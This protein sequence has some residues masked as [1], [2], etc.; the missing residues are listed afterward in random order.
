MQKSSS[1]F[2]SL[3]ATLMLLVVSAACA[4][5]V[6]EVEVTRYQVLEVPIVETQVVE[7]TREVEVVSEIQVEVTREIPVTVMPTPISSPGSAENPFQLIFL[8]TAAEE[9]IQIRGGFLL[10]HLAQST[11]YTFEAIIPSDENQA[12]EI[13]CNNPTTTIAMLT[14][15]QYVDANSRCGAFA[16]LTAT[17]F[18]VPYELGM[19]VSR[20][21]S[22]INV[23]EDISF[24]KIGVP[25]LSDVS[26]YQLFAKDIA[27]AGLPGVQFTEYGTSTSALIALLNKEIDIAA[28]IYNPP[29]M[30]VRED[31][32]Q[33]GED[34][35][36]IWRQL[37]IAP[38][39]NP[40]GFV[41][42]N[43]GPETGGYRIR[44]ARASIF[45]TYPTIFDETK[46]LLLSR[47]YPNEMIAL[48]SEFPIVAFNPVVNSIIG[49]TNSEACDQAMC[50]SDFYQWDGVQTIN[51]GFYNVVRELNR[52]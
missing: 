1:I 35:P 30:P 38:R 6:T 15:E 43:G 2:G 13:V 46:I 40:V 3:I 21:S 37:G 49:F 51:D 18:D 52:D 26:T 25:S 31:A 33:Y 39:R 16:A 28:G 10:D 45:D 27:D 12:V 22:V 7:V 11:G 42:V 23:F 44:D 9:L 8:P 48:G 29:M 24:K 47:P 14:P 19:L 4:P 36:E 17:K 50:A 32:W 41:E 20:T 5:P 34:S